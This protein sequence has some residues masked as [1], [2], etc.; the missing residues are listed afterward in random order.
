MG[1]VF[2]A[3]RGAE[4]R[5]PTPA[6]LLLLPLSERAAPLGSAWRCGKC[7]ETAPQPLRRRESGR[8]GGEEGSGAAVPGWGWGRKAVQRGAGCASPRGEGV[9]PGR[10][11]EKKGEKMRWR[12][13]W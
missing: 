4:Q 10:E 3:G 8:E 2:P 12:P 11:G 7:R 9:G 5:F 13:A 6:L 1:V